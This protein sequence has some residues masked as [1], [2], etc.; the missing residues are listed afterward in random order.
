[1]LAARRQPFLETQLSKA[2]QVLVSGTLDA[3][4]TEV[5][6]CEAVIGIAVFL[7]QISSFGCSKSTPNHIGDAKRR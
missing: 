4:L 2:P 7:R 5:V 6:C 3:G 1:M